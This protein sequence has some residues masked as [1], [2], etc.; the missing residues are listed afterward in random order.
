M[1]PEIIK[2]LVETGAVGVIA[3]LVIWQL[4]GK[5]DLLTSSVTTLHEKV[6]VLLDRMAK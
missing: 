2:A 5:M 1:N 4:G 6:S 3:G